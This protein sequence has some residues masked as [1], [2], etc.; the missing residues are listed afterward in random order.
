MRKW[1][2]FWATVLLLA[3]PVFA[4]SIP[5]SAEVKV[6]DD[7]V[8]PRIVLHVTVPDGHKL[9]AD[10][11]EVT[12]A[13]GKELK[14]ITPPPSEVVYDVF[15]E[16]N[17]RVFKHSFVAEYALPDSSEINVKLFGCSDVACYPPAILTFPVSKAEVVSALP[18]VK[19]VEVGDEPDWKVLADEFEVVASGVGFMDVKAFLRFLDTDHANGTGF[20]K[21]PVE[22]FMRFGWVLTALLILLGGLALNL[23]PCVLPMIP[24]NLAIIG[25]GAQASS[26]RTG[27]LLGGVYGIGIALTYGLLGLAVVLTGSKF[28]ALNASPWFN[29]A[30]VLVFVVLGLAMFDVI[31]IDFSRFQSRF[32]AGGD[33]SRYA[34]AVMMGALVAI[35]AGACVAPV[36]IAVLLLSSNLYASGATMG[37][38]L[39]FVLGLGMALPWPFVGAGI[40]C[41]PKP[42]N[43]MKAVKIA[44]GVLIFAVAIYYGQLTYTLFQADGIVS[45]QTVESGGLS[46]KDGLQKAKDED[47]LVLIDFWATWCKN[48]MAMKKT[49]LKDVAV[50]DVL[51]DFVFI[52][53][54]AEDPSQPEIAA[55]MD[56]FQARGLPTFV[57]LKPKD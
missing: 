27:F 33:H 49:T 3:G 44:F 37:L 21:S 40:S 11:F 55:V 15:Y 16:T 20:L 42:G 14:M 8:S 45:A 32:G 18:S 23:T 28:G 34:I 31:V 50:K 43:W 22:F 36:V 25:A 13:G 2:S 56:Y 47:R 7:K 26:K 29:L 54:Q 51:S 24:I 9:Y 5:F 57:I 48:C 30:V 39:P 53:Y 17:K 46:L 35:L 41:L 6:I 12:D 1:F 4:Q 10:A 19:A 52:P 38:L